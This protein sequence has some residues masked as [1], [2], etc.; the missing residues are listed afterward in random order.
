MKMIRT[1]LL[2]PVVVALSCPVVHAQMTFTPL[3]DL[4]GG[5][6]FSEA[7]AVSSDGSVVV[8]VSNSASGKEEAFRWTSAT[9]MVGLSDLPGGSFQ[10]VARHVSSDGSVIVGYSESASGQTAFRWTSSGGMVSL[11]DLP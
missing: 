8:G 7:T 9:G 1:C 4:P 5:T 11:G 2:A 3:G 6:F 10:S